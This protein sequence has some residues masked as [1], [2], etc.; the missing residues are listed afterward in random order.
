MRQS[1]GHTV[2]P[3]VPAARTGHTGGAGLVLGPAGD[4]PDTPLRQRNGLQQ[5]ARPPLNQPVQPI[6]QQYITMLVHSGELRIE[7][8][9]K[10]VDFNTFSSHDFHIFC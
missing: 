6:Y 9:V 5:G 8:T 7:I 1:Q 3:A 2:R 10:L 4:H